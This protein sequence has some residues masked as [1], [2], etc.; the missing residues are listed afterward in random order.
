MIVVRVLI[1]MKYLKIKN[2]L[3]I[4]SLLIFAY[5]CAATP[6]VKVQSSP[7]GA[8]VTSRSSDGSTR[9]LGK[10]PLSVSSSDLGGGGRLSTLVISKDGFQDQTLFLG[11]DRGSENYDINVSLRTQAEDPKLLDAKERQEKLA[12]NMVR[13]YNLLNNKRYDE[14]RAILMNLTQEYPH[15]SVGYDLLGTLSYLQKDL[16][17]ARTYY[18]RSLQINPENVETKQMIDRLK[19]MLQ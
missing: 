13:A 9:L 18:E 2:K 7:E 12:K 5:G 1:F 3:F 11:R 17:S 6:M 15:V 16:Q 10:T 19:G 8:S 14:A 4:P